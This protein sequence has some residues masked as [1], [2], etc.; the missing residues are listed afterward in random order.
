MSLREP[1]AVLGRAAERLQ[2]LAAALEER[3]EAGDEGIG[4][5]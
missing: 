4:N 5:P 3:L 1:Q 2:A